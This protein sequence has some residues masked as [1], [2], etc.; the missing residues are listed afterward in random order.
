ML[1][2]IL[3]ALRPFLLL[4]L[5]LFLPVHA[6]ATDPLPSPDSFFGNQ[7]FSAAVLS[8]DARLLAVRLAS[9]SGRNEL[10]VIDLADFSVR[11][12]ASFFDADVGNFRWVNAQRLVFDSADYQRALGQK[13]FAPGLFAVDAD[14]KQ[15]RQLVSRTGRAPQARTARQLLP[16]NTFL[17]GDVGEQNSD[18][19]YVQHAKFDGV[20]DIEYVDLQ[21]L[22]TRTGAVQTVER[23]SMARL[24]M[25]D[26]QGEPRI[27]LAPEGELEVVYYREPTSGAW[28]KLGQFARFTGAGGSFVPQFF[29]PDGTLYVRARKDSDKLALYTYDLANNKIGDTPVVS[30]TGYDFLGGGIANA[31]KLLGMR[32][33]ADAESTVWFDEN[34]KALQQAVD[35]MLPNTI[36]NM[37][38]AR[39]AQTPYVV[40][41]SYS[42]LQ[43]I[44]YSLFDTQT[45]RL[46]PVGARR[47]S[48]HPQQMS[49]MALV[50]YQA[51][52]GLD[53]PAF[54]TLPYGKKAQRLPM[55]VPVHGGP[56]ARD[57]WG[58]DPQVQ[59]LASRGYAV[60]EPQF[61][62][63]TGFG[64]KHF[65]SGWKQWGLGM[66]NDLA[67]GARWAIAQGTV[68]PKRIC[69]AGQGYGGYAALM[70]LVND[71]GLFKC[72]VDMG[73]MTDFRLLLEGSWRIDSTLPEEW[74]Q[75]GMPALIGD[76]GKDAAQLDATSPLVQAARIRQ[77]VLMGHGGYDGFVPVAH[78]SKLVDAVKPGNPDIELVVYDEEGHVLNL[79][80]NRIDFWSRVEKFL[81]RHIGNH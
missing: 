44:V 75:Y 19:V 22:N 77:P 5:L 34:M 49:S 26:H 35:A 28:R 39:R 9:K 80:K 47:P 52:D 27:A 65:T 2:S 25:L 78:A 74:K 14:G 13:R 64:R 23:P 38:V 3:R 1:P 58:W 16:A 7:A 60:L 32:Y 66:Q 17:L 61:R 6:Q 51:R 54:L 40:V 33:Q 73:G 62:G 45:R 67:D 59:F 37:S 69:I 56:Y 21:R 29:G 70:G 76:V 81:E 53:I 46:L 11:T 4:P 31:S 71:P 10:A 42:D 72:A 8:P 79:P 36:N 48:I 41:A 50:H 57:S 15:F 55:V 63:S 68:D 20:S 43:P 18:F 12:V 24:W 30:V